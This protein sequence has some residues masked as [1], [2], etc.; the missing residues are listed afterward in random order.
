MLNNA[1]LPLLKCELRKSVSIC[2]QPSSPRLCSRLSCDGMFRRLLFHV[3]RPQ[4]KLVCTWKCMI[5]GN[6]HFDHLS[7]QNKLPVSNKL[8]ISELISAA[9]RRHV[10]QD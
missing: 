4:M 3:E 1:L 9:I 5:R 6:W 8:M 10:W 7:P 2:T